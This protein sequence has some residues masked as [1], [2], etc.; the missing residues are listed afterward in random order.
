MAKLIKRGERVD[1]GILVNA[2][3]ASDDPRQMRRTGDYEILVHEQGKHKFSVRLVLTEAEMLDMIGRF[4]EVRA[5]LQRL[6]NA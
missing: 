6:N 1:A 2:E 3:H 4:F 5:L